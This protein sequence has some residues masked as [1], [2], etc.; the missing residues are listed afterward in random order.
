MLRGCLRQI[1]MRRRTGGN[2]KD[3]PEIREFQHF[4]RE[5]K[6]SE[7]DGIERSTQDT[8]R[9]ADC[10]IVHRLQR[11]A[12][13]VRQHLRKKNDE[14]RRSRTVDHAMII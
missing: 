13:S 11:Q 14:A 6:M 2:K 5:P 7:M 4:L 3:L 1:A 8:N 10:F 9:I 12:A